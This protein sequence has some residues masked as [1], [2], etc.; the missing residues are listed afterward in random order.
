M[1]CVFPHLFFILL[2]YNDFFL[3]VEGYHHVS[4]SW[5]DYRPKY[6]YIYLYIYHVNVI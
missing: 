3:L 4:S 2:A 1:L 6:K 5:G